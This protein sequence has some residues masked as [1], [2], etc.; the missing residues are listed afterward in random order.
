MFCGDLTRPSKSQLRHRSGT[1]RGYFSLLHPL[2]TARALLVVFVRYQD[3][4]V[5]LSL[6]FV[7]K[8]LDLAPSVS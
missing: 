2:E 7:A 1:R 6:S 5:D 4:G 3:G 8:F